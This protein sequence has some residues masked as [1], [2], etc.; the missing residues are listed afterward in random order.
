MLILIKLKVKFYYI[1]K[2]EIKI[3]FI[4]IKF[5]FSKV[6]IHV[7]NLEL[8]YTILELLNPKVIFFK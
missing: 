5:Y 6:I 8:N 4:S 1:I 7:P 2:Y 3:N